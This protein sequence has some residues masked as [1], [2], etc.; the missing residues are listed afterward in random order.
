MLS[1]IKATELIEKKLLFKLSFKEGVQLFFHKKVCQTCA[2]YEKQSILI[3][4]AIEKQ[5]HHPEHFEQL[6]VNQKLELQEKIKQAFSQ[7]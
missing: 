5:H 6:S 4:Q 1:C 7:K 3:D 2:A